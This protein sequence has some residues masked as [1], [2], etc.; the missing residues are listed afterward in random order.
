MKILNSDNS[1]HKNN[2]KLVAIVNDRLQEIGDV[3]VNDEIY[4]VDKKALSQ[5]ISDK[6][7]FGKDGAFAPMLKNTIEKV[8][9]PEQV[10]KCQKNKCV[11]L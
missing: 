2:Q 9:E 11:I 6:N 3:F 4:E 10:K 5:L 8:L 7:L 1:Y